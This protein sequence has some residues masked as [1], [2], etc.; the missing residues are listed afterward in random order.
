MSNLTIKARLTLLGSGTVVLL[1]AMIGLVFFQSRSILTRQVD[2][3][4][5]EVVRSNAR[6]V[7][8]YFHKLGIVA[9][10]MRDVAAELLETGKAVTDDDLES[11]MARFYRSCA[12]DLNIV[13][14]YV[15]LESTGKVGTGGDWVEKPDYDAR[16]R[17]WYTLAVQEDRVVLTAPYVDANTGK[18]VVTVAAPAKGADGRLLGVA[19]IDVDLE[20]LSRIVTGYRI[21]GKGYGFLLDPQGLVLAHPVPEL[22]MKENM[23]KAG[24][25]VSPEMA[26]AGAKMLTGGEGYADYTFR[27][28]EFRAFYAPTSHGFI[29]ALAFPKSELYALVASLA[30]RQLAAGATVLLLLG[31]MLVLLA[32]SIVGPIHG[33]SQTLERIGRLDLTRDESLN[34]LT[35]QKAQKTE[36]G[37]MVR[38]LESLQ[39]ALRD[40]VRSIKDEADRTAASAESLA[41]LSEESVASMEE[42]KASVDHVASLSESNS[43][44][45]QQTNAGIEEV[46]S[47]ASTAAHAASDGAEASGRTTSLSEEAVTQVNGVV[48]EMNTVGEKSR[49]SAERLRKVAESVSSISGFVATIRSIADQTNLLALNAAI[50]AARAGEAGRGF[51]VVAEEVRKLA[52]ESAGAAKEV[53]TLI[54]SLQTDTKGS[55]E[56][57]EESGKVLE[58]TIAK[59]HEAQAKLQEALAQI[60]RVND[61][62]QNIAATSEEQAAAS[63]EMAQGIDQATKSTIQ[64]VETIESIRHSTEETAHASESVAQESQ[65]LAEGAEHLKRLLARFVLDQAAGTIKSLGSGR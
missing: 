43:A 61:A 5:L 13:D 62:M 51:A 40:S 52:E 49:L 21:F 17:P 34:W 38:S 25:D 2:T 22:V 54:T 11:P 45:L 7:D 32:K 10:G 65:K 1:S 14:L 50:E 24:S 35:A 8:E 15:G 16:K 29:L 4:G 28:E 59:A 23:A 56:V 42:V 27:G 64:V 20:T 30:L 53:E 39:E 37:L 41:A 46:S 48:T 26:A 36:I 31:V 3:G 18:L 44:A 19:G 47:G 9:L 57:T 6:E 58:G 12:K 33:V 55:L 60:A 63:G